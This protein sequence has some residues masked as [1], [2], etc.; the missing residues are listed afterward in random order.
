M[1]SVAPVSPITTQEYKN[2]KFA[3]LNEQIYGY[4]HG[5]RPLVLQTMQVEDKDAIEARLKRDNLNYHLQPAPGGKNLNVFLGDKAC[6]DVVKTF[7]DTPLGKLTPEK[8]FI[9]GVLLGY[10][11]TKQC[12]RYLKLKD[13]EAQQAK[14]NQKLNLVA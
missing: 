14:G 9:L 8:D 11:K 12:E 5:I 4:K 1:V 6:V 3:V 7:G 2:N 10:D 13:K